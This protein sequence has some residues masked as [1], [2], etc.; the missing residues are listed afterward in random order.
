VRN[1]RRPPNHRRWCSLHQMHYLTWA[2]AKQTQ[3]GRC[4]QCV[5]EDLRYAAAVQR[6]EE[7]EAATKGPGHE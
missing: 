7:A 1:V 2:D 4:A 6:R 3:L 5:D